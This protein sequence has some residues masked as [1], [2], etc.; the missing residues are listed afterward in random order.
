MRRAGALLLGHFDEFVRQVHRPMLTEDVEDDS[1]GQDDLSED[2][3]MR[4]NCCV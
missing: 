3:E 1:L 2:V 4:V